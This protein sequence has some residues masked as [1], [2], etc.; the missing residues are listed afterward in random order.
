MLRVLALC[1]N[2]WYRGDCQTA[3]KDSSVTLPKG[4]EEP[5]QQATTLP[6]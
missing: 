1:R 2:C 6:W 4:A 5:L 3:R